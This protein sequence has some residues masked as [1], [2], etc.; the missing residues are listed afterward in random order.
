MNNLMNF[1]EY[2]RNEEY[3]WNTTTTTGKDFNYKSAIFKKGDLVLISKPWHTS[4]EGET[5][6]ATIVNIE[7]TKVQLDTWPWYADLSQIMRK[8]TEEE[9]Y[10]WKNKSDKELMDQENQDLEDYRK[11]HERLI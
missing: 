11:T 7:G 6:V 1:N 9:Y 8:A 4:K 3:D 5:S 2:S 10:E